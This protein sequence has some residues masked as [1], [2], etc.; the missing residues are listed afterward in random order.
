MYMRLDKNRL[1]SREGYYSASKFT[2]KPF[3]SKKYIQHLWID[4]NIWSACF[5]H[6]N[7]T[8]CSPAPPQLC[9]SKAL[10]IMDLLRDPT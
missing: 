6:R 4:S 3:K 7:A 1:P 9:L 5:L 8:L 10:T 2:K